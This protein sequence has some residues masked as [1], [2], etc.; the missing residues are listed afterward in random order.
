MLKNTHTYCVLA[1]LCNSPFTV[2]FLDRTLLPSTGTPRSDVL[3]DTAWY[4]VDE[5]GCYCWL[6]QT[7]AP[8]NHCVLCS[9]LCHRRWCMTSGNERLE[10]AIT[11][12]TKHWWLGLLLVSAFFSMKGLVMY[13]TV[14][15]VMAQFIVLELL[16]NAFFSN[17]G[18]L[19]LFSLIL[20]PSCGLPFI[21][22]VSVCAMA[23][24]TGLAMLT[25]PAKWNHRAVPQTAAC[26]S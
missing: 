16:N 7:P 11:I 24:G 14:S 3:Y 25:Y 1:D 18:V 6:Q 8:C 9:S 4:V 26:H 5:F 10:T 23:A 20:E 12:N 13:A 22:A 15:N 2:F 21:A 19:S 17:E